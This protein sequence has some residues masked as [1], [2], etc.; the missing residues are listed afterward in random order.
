M[1]PNRALSSAAGIA[2]VRLGLLGS[3][4]SFTK[5]LP[6][7]QVAYRVPIPPVLGGGSC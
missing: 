3:G 5:K 7:C 2:K 4:T 1:A 6:P